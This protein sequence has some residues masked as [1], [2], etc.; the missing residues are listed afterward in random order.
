MRVSDAAVRY[1]GWRGYQL[2]CRLRQGLTGMERHAADL[3]NMYAAL[4]SSR[5]N[6]SKKVKVRFRSPLVGREQEVRDLRLVLSLTC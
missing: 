4:N 5:T 3:A 2:A 6:R 1:A